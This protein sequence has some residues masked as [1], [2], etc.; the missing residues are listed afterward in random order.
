VNGVE[1]KHAKHQPKGTWIYLGQGY[2]EGSYPVDGAF[3]IDVSS[4]GTRVR[5]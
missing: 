2:R 3:E 1:A 4:V 5:R